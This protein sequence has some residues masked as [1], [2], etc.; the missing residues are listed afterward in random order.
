MSQSSPG[1]LASRENPKPCFPQP[2]TQVKPVMLDLDDTS[3]ANTPKYLFPAIIAGPAWFF[4]TSLLQTKPG[5]SLVLRVR[6]PAISKR[7]FYISHRPSRLT[8][9]ASRHGN[10]T[11]R[12]ETIIPCHGCLVQSALHSAHRV[13]LVRPPCILI[14]SQ[15]RSLY[16][17]TARI[18]FWTF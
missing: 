10:S 6:S 9:V 11:G 12:P 16:S 5:S 14:G 18:F 2:T 8:H 13:L 3:S 7:Y 1:V 15:L 17:T 4:L